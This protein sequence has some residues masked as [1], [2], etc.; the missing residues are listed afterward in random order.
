MARIQR[1]DQAIANQI[2]AGEVI[3]RP[4]SVV[5]ELC[6][7]AIDA[8]ASRIVIR[9][10][11]GGIQEIEVIDNGSGMSGEDVE[12]ALEPH[13]TSKI[14]RIEDLDNLHS[15]G[16][17]GEALASIASVSHFE[18]LS[19]DDESKTGTKL[20]S[21][22]GETRELS[23]VA[24]SRGT[25]ITVRNLF[26]NTPARYKFLKRDA[27]EAAK[28]CKV[29]NELAL[30]RP[31][32]SFHLISKGEELVHSPGN[33][34]LLSA[35]YAIYGPKLA[36]QMFYLEADENESCRVSGYLSRPEAARKS[37]IHQQIFINHRAIQSKVICKAVEE[38]YKPF[39]VKSLFP[40][41][42]LNIDLPLAYVDV[43]VHPQKLEV[44]F[45]N[46]QQVFE[47][48]YRHIRQ[49]LQAQLAML[50]EESN[51]F[52]ERR[53][54]EEVK[55]ELS[56]SSAD[57][58]ALLQTESNVSPSSSSTTTPQTIPQFQSQVAFN[59]EEVV[60]TNDSPLPNPVEAI[61]TSARSEERGAAY[62]DGIFAFDKDFYQN[63]SPQQASSIERISEV[64]ISEEREIFT[65]SA[66]ETVS[67]QSSSELTPLPSRQLSS[68]PIQEIK[69][70]RFVGH[71]F[72]TYLIFENGD[73]V[74]MMDQHA[75][76]EKVLYEAFRARYDHFNSATHSQVLLCPLELELSADERRMLDEAKE[77]LER[78]GFS[79]TI[80]PQKLELHS[81]PVEKSGSDVE[82]FFR[83]ILADLLD[84]QRD[85]EHSEADAL[86]LVIATMACKAAVKAHDH[87]SH[88]EVMELV[89]SMQTLQN[90][91]HCP[92]GRPVLIK[93]RASDLE[94]L[95][96]R[97]VHA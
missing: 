86:D 38:A 61:K 73:Y 54:A 31:D 22:P 8:G 23:Q 13:A 17:R 83:S 67:P 24:S 12:L 7:N 4:A 75:A 49:A 80:Y 46:D 44:R 88:S 95:F 29:I 81:I 37:R 32:I 69:E 89:A 68:G 25:Q 20:V 11:R 34:E 9:I 40:A 90:P 27:T 1:L 47:S 64:K 16:F 35:I 39:L 41:Y 21:I 91:Y 65:Q 43:N 2:A 36:D 92:H 71:L 14:R 76:H 70:A 93:R 5:K 48:V 28:V 33:G 50:H 42:V 59:Q 62:E 63:F 94:K 97:I 53:D 10:E 15:L 6:E 78:L 52:L 57:A 55:R 51:K 87:L 96:Q 60:R 84:N 77:V 45:W 74:Y 85:F 58:S 19:K 79:F 82:T 56:P 66:M 30:A 18:V 72:D 26:F 3:E